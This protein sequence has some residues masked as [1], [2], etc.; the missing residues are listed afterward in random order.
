VPAL[1]RAFEQQPADCLGA[2]R[3]ARLAAFLRGDPGAHQRLDQERDLGRLADALAAFDRNQASA[4]AQRR[5]PQIQW[6]AIIA[7]RPSAPMRSTLEAATSGA[8][9]GAM[10]GAVTTSLPTGSP[11]LTGA[12]IGLS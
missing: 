2:G 8:S 11:C 7:T 3:P 6:P 4:F 10:S 1:G 12:A 5:L 9:T